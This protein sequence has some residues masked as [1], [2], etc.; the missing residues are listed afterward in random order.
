MKCDFCGNHGHNYINCPHEHAAAEVDEA[1]IRR[2]ML[3]TEDETGEQKL[4]MQADL[5][6]ALAS[7]GYFLPVEA[8]DEVAKALW[9]TGWRRSRTEP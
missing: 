7:A 8:L 9:L 4:G 5:Q 6:N 3:A 1:N 2:E